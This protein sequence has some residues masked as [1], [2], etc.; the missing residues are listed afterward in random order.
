MLILSFSLLAAWIRRNALRA[1]VSGGNTFVP[2]VQRVPLDC[3]RSADP[4][5]GPGSDIAPLIYRWSCATATF[6]AP[7]LS[8]DGISPLLFRADLRG[9]GGNHPQQNVSIF[10]PQGGARYILTCT[11]SKGPRASSASVYIEVSARNATLPS[12]VLDPVSAVDPSGQSVA[13]GATTAMNHTG[14]RVKWIQVSG[15]TDEDILDLTDPSVALPQ[16]FL[17]TA[18]GQAPS[19]WDTAPLLLLNP[20]V[21]TPGGTYTFRLSATTESGTTYADVVVPV[22]PGPRGAGGAEVGSLAVSPMEGMALSTNFTL[23]CVPP[24]PPCF[25]LC[26]PMPTFIS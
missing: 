26:A 4:E 22:L 20:T 12:I 5:I 3:G 23:T 2:S 16:P 10:S 8:A 9:V 1:L 18:S 6:G 11:V 15:P 19:S 14:A 25:L 13:L 21:L 17:T 24:T 7:C